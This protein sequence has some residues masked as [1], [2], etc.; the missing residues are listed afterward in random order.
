MKSLTTRALIRAHAIGEWL[1]MKNIL[2]SLMVTFCVTLSVFAD[3]QLAQYCVQTGGEVV[4]EW[5]CPATGTLRIGATC[6]QKN[7]LGQV[8]F[9]NGCSAPGG[10]YK[11][12]FFKACIIHDL[13]YHHE[14]QTNG[15]SKADCDKQFLTDMKSICNTTNSF[16][17][18]L[19]LECGIAAQTFYLAVAKAG[20]SAFTCSKENVNYPIEMD[21]LPLPSPVPFFI[22]N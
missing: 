19:S 17:L 7:A 2:V 11:T 20:D 14:P 18:E 16:N 12:F 8:M 6:K 21:Q 3:Q 4:K 5:T 10:K 13:C 22:E 1:N 15:K 9:F